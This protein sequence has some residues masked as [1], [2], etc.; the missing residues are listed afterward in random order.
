MEKVKIRDVK[1]GAVIEVAKDI[2]SD[3]IATKNFEIY[4]EEEAQTLFNKS[5]N[6]SMK[7]D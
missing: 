3:Y 2:A 6:E 5:K 7:N 4:K 1:V